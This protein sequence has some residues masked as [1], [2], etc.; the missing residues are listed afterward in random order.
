VNVAGSGGGTLE[1]C[2]GTVQLRIPTTPSAIINYIDQDMNLI[3]ASLSSFSCIKN[4]MIYTNAW[5]SSSET[6]GNIELL[7]YAAGKA[8]FFVSGDFTLVFG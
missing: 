2:M 4:S 1:M 8:T 3:S 7:G 6:S 5:S